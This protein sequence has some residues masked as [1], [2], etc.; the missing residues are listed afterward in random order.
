MHEAVE[1]ERRGAA[2]VIRLNRP[3]A[4]NAWNAALGSELLRRCA[5]SPATT[6]CAPS[7]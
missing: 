3:E 2:A 7:A 5:P 6:A 4:L 1:L